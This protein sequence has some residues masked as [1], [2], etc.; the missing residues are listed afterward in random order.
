MAAGRRRHFLRSQLHGSLTPAHAYGCGAQCFVGVQ[1]ASIFNL[2]VCRRPQAATPALYRDVSRSPVTGV[3]SCELE[4]R[5]RRIRYTAQYG[6]DISVCLMLRR[7]LTGVFFV[8]VQTSS[9]VPPDKVRK[10]RTHSA[11]KP[12]LRGQHLKTCHDAADQ[13]CF[14]P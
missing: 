12:D 9:Q 3:P 13:L 1:R 4:T 14:K 10:G 2:P 6:R 11:R 7:D 8:K 5:S